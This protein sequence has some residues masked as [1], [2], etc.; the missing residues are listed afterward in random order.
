MRFARALRALEP[1]FLERV[2]PEHSRSLEGR[3]AALRSEFGQL[4]DCA[5]EQLLRA[6]GMQDPRVVAPVYLVAEAPRPG[7]VTHRTARGAAC[8]IDA[9]AHPTLQIIEVLLHEAAHVFD[10]ATQSGPTALGE[11]RD[12]LRD[13]GFTTADR[14]LRDAPHT[15]MFVASAWTVR[16]VLDPTHRDHGELAGYYDRVG[17]TAEVVRAPWIEFVSGD[18][19]R[20][21]AIERIVAGLRPRQDDPSERG[22]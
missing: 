3:A 22:K 20:R 15:A 7:A 8:W 21:A 13:A 17:R 12:A 18:G 16:T 5:V 10:V 19:D 6:L 11:L 9:D 1:A 2:W 4:A 14:E